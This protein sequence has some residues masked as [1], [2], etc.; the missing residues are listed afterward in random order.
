[1]WRSQT[2]QA[3]IE[4]AVT[5]PILIVLFLGFLAAGLTAQA[6]VDLNTSVFL[7]AASAVTAPAGNS[8]LGGQYATDTYNGS[9]RH[10]PELNSNGGVG[11]TGSW[12]PNPDPPGYVVTCS[13]QATLLFKGT[14]LAIVVP[15]NPVLKATAT[16]H[17]S[18][19]RST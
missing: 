3:L 6:L 10:V 1:M 15:F 9:M 16:A 5:I 18:P 7:A 11:C 17:G 2:G 12:N 14:P 19:Y 4:A 13:A 8:T